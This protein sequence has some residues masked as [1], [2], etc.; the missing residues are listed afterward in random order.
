MPSVMNNVVNKVLNV[1]KEFFFAE[2]FQYGVLNLTPQD[3]GQDINVR[4]Y[5]NA[6][7]V[8]FSLTPHGH[9]YNDLPPGECYIS[10]AHVT[11]RGFKFRV[12]LSVPCRVDWFVIEDF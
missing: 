12:N 7:K 6:V 11:P 1:V 9:P 2:A 5:G 10:E 4:C 8:W 3:N